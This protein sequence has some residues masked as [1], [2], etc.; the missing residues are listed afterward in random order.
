MYKAV[1]TADRATRNPGARQK[2]DTAA[3]KAARKDVKDGAVTPAY[4]PWRDDIVQLLN[5]AMATELVSVMRYRRNQFTAEG[6]TSPAIAGEFMVHASEDPSHSDRLA[7]RIVQLGGRPDFRPDSLSSRSQV[8]Y[9][10]TT[11]LKDM[12]MANLVAERVAFES[13]RQ[14]IQ[15]VDNKDPRPRGGGLKAS[16]LKKKSTPTS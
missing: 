11:A 10:K 3:L 4:G 6:L 8:N 5:D 1:E 9:D 12:L 2:F 7:E 15:L 14:M 16:W 13:Y